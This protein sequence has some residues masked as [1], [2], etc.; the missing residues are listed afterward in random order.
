M[1]TTPCHK[2]FTRL[3]ARSLV[4]HMATCMKMLPSKNG[5]LYDLRPSAVI[6]GYP[7]PDYNKIR[8]TLGAYEVHC[9]IILPGSRVSDLAGNSHAVKLNKA[10]TKQENITGIQYNFQGST[11]SGFN[12][13]LYI[14]LLFICANYHPSPLPITASICFCCH[15]LPLTHCVW[16]TVQYNVSADTILRPI[17]WTCR[18]FFGRPFA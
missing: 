7:N 1:V 14:L 9:T 10:H 8:I 3:M 11:W 4:Q 16:Y 18:F 6:L 13:L 17:R 12:F 5:I 15:G 2:F